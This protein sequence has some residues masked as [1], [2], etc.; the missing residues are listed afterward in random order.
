MARSTAV[1][2]AQLLTAK[3]AQANLNSLNSTSYVSTWNLWLWIVAYGQNLFEQF[4]DLFQANLETTATSAPVFS[5]AW[6]QNQLLNFQYS[7]TIP[8]V[9]SMS[10]AFAITYA[11]INAALRIITQAA[12]VAISNGNV[13]IK[14]ASNSSALSGPQL[15]ALNSFLSAIGIPGTQFS[16]ISQSADL[17]TCTCSVFY[18]ATFSGV[19][20][21]NLQAAYNT[22]LA[23]IPFNGSFEVSDLEAALKAVQGVKDV[24]IFVLTATPNGGGPS[25]L[26]NT[27]SGNPTLISRNWN[28][29]AGYATDNG[30]NTF[31]TNLTLIAQ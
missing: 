3:Q 15:S 20:T 1:I 8:Q 25:F 27:V 10:A 22:F 21:A 13:D 14:V 7:A 17:I 9:V 6:Y 19:I 28:T 24:V 5:A 31:T 26:V 29:I 4:C 30:S 23:N 11:T 18:D 12:V 2:Y 16:V